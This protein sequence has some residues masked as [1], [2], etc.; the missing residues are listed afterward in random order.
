MDFVN[1]PNTKYAGS[2]KGYPH[3]ERETVTTNADSRRILFDKKHANNW[4]LELKDK[5]IDKVPKEDIF[6]A[7][8]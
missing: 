1:L 7:V 3:M 8:E 2:L 4:S 6:D 5:L